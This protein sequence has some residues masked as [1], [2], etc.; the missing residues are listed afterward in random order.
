MKYIFC[1]SPGRSGTNYL[2]HLF[3]QADKVCAVHEPEHQYRKYSYLSPIHWDLKNHTFAESYPQRRSIKLFQI[4]DLLSGSG[5]QIYAE[6]NPLFSTLWHDV[7]LDEFRG[8]DVTVLIVRRNA[9][10]VLK[11]ILDLGWFRKI[12]G[13]NW[14]VT[15]FSVNSL[16]PPIGPEQNATAADLV[17]GH[18]LNTEMYAQK[19]KRLCNEAGHRIIEV[20]SNRLFGNTDQ[21]LEVL[22]QCGLSANTDTLSEF[23]NTK[24]TKHDTLHKPFNVSRNSCRDHIEKYLQTCRNKSLEVPDLSYI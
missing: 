8:Q 22:L 18:I 7:I 5:K 13:N 9:S 2:Y 10:E 21:V 15:P 17:T 20:H 12:N 6:T 23:I 24:K 4:S 11:S 14:M 1:V 19:I 16:I 3:A